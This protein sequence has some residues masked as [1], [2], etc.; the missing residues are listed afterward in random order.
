MAS[1]ST[2]SQLTF[3]L[4]SKSFVLAQLFHQQQEQNMKQFQ[5]LAEKIAASKHHYGRPMEMFFGAS[6]LPR[7]YGSNNQ[8]RQGRQ[9]GQI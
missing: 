1:T 5:L 7:L 6:I 4:V 2:D 8:R 3:A 9:S